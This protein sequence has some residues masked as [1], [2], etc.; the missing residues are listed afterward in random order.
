[1]NL[2]ITFVVVV[3]IA[4]T[5]LAWLSVAVDKFTSPFVSLLIFFPMF[6]LTIYL[7]WKL[8]VKITEPRST[9]RA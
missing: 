5:G 1:V 8:A 2:L 4:L 6:F 9:E 7:V 3:I